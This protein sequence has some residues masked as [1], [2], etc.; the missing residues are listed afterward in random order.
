MNEDIDE[1]LTPE[2]IYLICGEKLTKKYDLTNLYSV[3]TETS[4]ERKCPDCN[5][6]YTENVHLFYSYKLTRCRGCSKIYSK[7]YFKQN[8]EKIR[9]CQKR[10]IETRKQVDNC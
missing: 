6:T 10:Y 7:K 9:L 4:N 5:L 8:I 1:R 2:E 3:E